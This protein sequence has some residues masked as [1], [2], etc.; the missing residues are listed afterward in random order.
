MI[1]M[2]IGYR[3]DAGHGELWMGTSRRLSWRQWATALQGLSSAIRRRM[4]WVAKPEAQ[5]GKPDLEAAEPSRPAD[6]AHLEIPRARKW[7]GRYSLCRHIHTSSFWLC[8]LSYWTS[9]TSC[10]QGRISG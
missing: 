5:Q 9:T 2:M 3:T 4:C 6:V 7:R 1:W 8:R 10:F